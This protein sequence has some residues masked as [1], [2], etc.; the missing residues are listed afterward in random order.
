[1]TRDDKLRRVQVESSNLAELK[2]G[3]TRLVGGKLYGRCRDCGKVKRI[4]LLGGLHWC[5]P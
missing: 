4:G 5:N 2:L 1:M 3:E